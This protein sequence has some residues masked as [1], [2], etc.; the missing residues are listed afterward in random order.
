MLLIVTLTIVILLF[1]FF[2][3]RSI[4]EKLSEPN[5]GYSS[6][7]YQRIAETRTTGGHYDDYLTEFGKKEG[8]FYARYYK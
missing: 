3:A 8:E 2:S 4:S 5:L 6:G 1:M 7:G